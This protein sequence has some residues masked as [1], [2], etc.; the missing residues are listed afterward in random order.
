MYILAIII[1]SRCFLHFLID[2]QIFKNSLFRTECKSVT[3][4]CGSFDSSRHLKNETL[5][6]SSPIVWNFF[7][8]EGVLSFR[9]N[10]IQGFCGGMT[11]INASQNLA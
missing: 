1:R 2:E 4:S 8:V 5:K 6:C 9:G 10:S 3:S 11:L 7:E